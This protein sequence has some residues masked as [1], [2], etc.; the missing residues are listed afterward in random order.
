MATGPELLALLQGGGEGGAA[1][2]SSS[3]A[4]PIYFASTHGVYAINEGILE[5]FV[6]PPNTYIF[7]ASSVGEATLTNMDEPLWELIQNRAELA[8]YV[9]GDPSVKESIKKVIIRNLVYYKPGD[10]VYRRRFIL[11]PENRYEYNWGYF[12]FQQGDPIVPFPEGLDGEKGAY[13]QT[14]DKPLV[15]PEEVPNPPATPIMR[16]FRDEHYPAASAR[17]RA[18]PRVETGSNEYFIT[19]TRKREGYR[20]PAIFIFSSCASYW[21][22]NTDEG[23]KIDKAQI[24]D[25][26]RTQQAAKLNFLTMFPRGEYDRRGDS[27]PRLK[28]TGKPKFT[29]IFARELKVNPK[30]EITSLD[31][32]EEA[33]LA[34]VGHENPRYVKP[35]YPHIRVPQGAATIFVRTGEQRAGEFGYQVERSPT[36]KTWWTAEEINKA[37]S[38]GREL[39][40]NVGGEFQRLQRQAGPYTA[41]LR[42]DP[43]ATPASHPKKGGR[44]TRRVKRNSKRTSK[45]KHKKTR[46]TL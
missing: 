15:L 5:T 20:G 16:S 14:L 13:L 26:G 22:S 27:V 25:I 28:T 24:I 42:Q 1:G 2:G 10:I 43:A 31:P 46:R 44:R 6:V 34:K 4:A 23:K 29:E 12:K 33:Y 37:V 41:V 45:A 17:L 7:E 21:E 32:E 3:A 36:A 18:P 38:E 40:I 39:Y 9:S 8:K 11:E 30:Y 19:E 35:R